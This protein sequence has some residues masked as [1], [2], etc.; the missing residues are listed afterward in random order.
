MN[1]RPT[2]AKAIERL[3]KA[4]SAVPT[5]KQLP[6]DSQEFEKWRRDTR[7]AIEHTFRDSNGHLAEFEKIRFFASNPLL[8][9]SYTRD[10]HQAVYERGLES[11]DTLLA[12]MIYEVTEFWEDEVQL[13]QVDVLQEPRRDQPYSNLVFVVHGRD[14]GTKSMVA[15]FLEALDLVAIALSELPAQGQTIIEKFESNSDVEFAVILLTP[16]DTGSLLEEDKQ[17]PRA[18]QNVIFELG[19]FIGKLGRDRV[20]VLTKGEP[21]IPSNYAGGEYIPID[22]AGGWKMKLVRELKAAG[23]DVDANRVA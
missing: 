18:R 2:K 12:S 22:E 19:F 9:G 10:Q 3:R 6:Y 5:L 4:Q 15:R 17:N 14:E 1:Q 11:A 23:F 20:C 8:Y 21:E 7:I 13:K 16:D